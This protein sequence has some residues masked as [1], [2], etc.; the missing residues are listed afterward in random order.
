MDGKYAALEKYLRE[1]PAS[2]REVTLRFEQIESVLA[3][4]SVDSRHLRPGG[5]LKLP[6]ALPASAYEDERWWLHA[7]EAN[8]VTVRAWSAAGWRVGSLDVRARRVTFV[9]AG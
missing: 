4:K 2:Q 9:R 7:T 6:R 8:H 1:L 3:G 5:G